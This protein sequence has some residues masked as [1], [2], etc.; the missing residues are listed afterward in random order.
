[1]AYAPITCFNACCTASSNV[2]LFDVRM[3]S[4]RLT[5]TSR[6]GVALE[7]VTVFDQRL[8]QH[9]VIFDDTIVDQG[10]IARIGVVGMGVDVVRFAVSPNGCGRCRSFRPDP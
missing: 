3:Y 5:S 8:F 7:R 9:P 1:M 10:D 4:I 6:V 2:Q